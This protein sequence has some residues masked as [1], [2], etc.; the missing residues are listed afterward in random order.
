[1]IE[2]LNIVNFKSFR[3]A[4]LALK[5]LT[6]LIGANASG[7][8]N[9][10][11]GLQ[12]LSWIASGR[13]LND[14]LSAIRDEELVLRGTPPQLM[15]APGTD[16][17]TLGCRIAAPPGDEVGPLDLSISIGISEV[18]GV[19][20]VGERL[21]APKLATQ[22]PLYSAEPSSEYALRVA[23]NNF[24]KG[25]TKP[26]IECSPQRAVFTQLTSESAFKQ[27]NAQSR[28]VIPKAAT[29][30]ETALSRI[31]LLDP[32]PRRMRG[33]SHKQDRAL[34]SD[35]ANLSSVLHDLCVNHGRKGEVLDFVR[36]LPEQDISDIGFIE[37]PRGEM[38]VQLQE[39]F[40][41][42]PRAIEAALL[43]DGTL[44]VLAIAA[45]VHSVPPGSLLVVEEIDNGI[46]PSRAR[47]LIDRLN[48][49]AQQR[50][51]HM[52]VTTHNPALLDAVPDDVLPD[53][54]ACYRDP[55]DGSSRVVGLAEITD[56]PALVARGSL[57]DLVTQGVLDRFLKDKR[58]EAQRAA[59]AVD[60]FRQFRQ[61]RP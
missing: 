39:T 34:R 60:W 41:G 17:F 55:D 16:S 6:I 32:V 15:W 33:Y 52:L 54:L 42:R 4:R 22:V 29:H 25:G 5:P 53:V 49:T 28:R 3:E 11:E 48:A 43:S 26:T 19:R 61:A 21:Q 10:L 12:I 58:T 56:Y 23:Y 57:G 1:M 51:I 38:M 44:R 50:D 14:L 9:A 37:T 7:K 18:E 46:H 40:G 36:A 47:S 31:L 30:V 59:E 24:A 35:G 27:T 20:V 45:A 2:S 13:R 8:S